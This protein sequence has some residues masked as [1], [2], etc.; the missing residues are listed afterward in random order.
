MKRIGM[1]VGLTLAVGLAVGVISD[2]VLNA[3]QEPIKRTEL[4]KTD[5]VGIEGKGAVVR[6][7]EYAPG[8]EAGKHYHPA[9]VF[10]YVLEGSGIWEPEGQPPVTL[11]PG[12]VYYE[13]PRQVHTAKN[14]STSA[15]LKLL[16]WSIVEKGQPSIVPVK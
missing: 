4:L 7:V 16:S 2:R 1:V 9:H 11:K 8:A 15:P 3:Q 6:L 14:A 13:P 10:L 12:D 5:L